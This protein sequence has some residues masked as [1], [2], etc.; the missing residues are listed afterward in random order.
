MT[1]YYSIGGRRS[2]REEEEGVSA[3]KK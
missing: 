3:R 2:R 1:H